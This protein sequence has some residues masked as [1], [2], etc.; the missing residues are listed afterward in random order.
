MQAPL[1]YYYAEQTATKKVNSAD[2]IIRKEAT[3]KIALFA[4]ILACLLLA[5]II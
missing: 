5:V 2:A 3:Q 4:G 1:N